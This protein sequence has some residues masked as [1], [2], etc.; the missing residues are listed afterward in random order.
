MGVVVIIILKWI[1]NTFWKC[2]WDSND[3][4]WALVNIVCIFTLRERREISWPPDI[5]FP[6][7]GLT[8]C[9]MASTIASS[10]S[11]LFERLKA[12]SQDPTAV[13]VCARNHARTHTHTHTHTELKFITHISA[14]RF[15]CMNGLTI[16]RH[17]VV[18]LYFLFVCL[19]ICLFVCWEL[20]RCLVGSLNSC[21]VDWFASFVRSQCSR[22]EW[23]KQWDAKIM[24][25]WSTCSLLRITHPP[26]SRAHCCECYLPQ[27]RHTALRRQS[28]SC[29]SFVQLSR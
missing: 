26:P 14:T 11:P 21:M 23:F 16:D 7:E 8:D 22:C 17:Q 19:S 9:Q 25:E 13:S 29:I 6:S 10:N 2:T 12:F 18:R 4:R 3:W 27:Q 28:S 1:L 15:V 24:M 5:R 20:L